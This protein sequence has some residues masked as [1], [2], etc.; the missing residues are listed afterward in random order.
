MMLAELDKEKVEEKQLY[1]KN[2]CPAGR[3]YANALIQWLNSMMDANLMR[4]VMESKSDER[5]SQ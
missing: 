1:E 5:F 4:M 3:L 2:M